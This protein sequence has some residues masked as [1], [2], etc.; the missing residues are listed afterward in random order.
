MD[1]IDNPMIQRYLWVCLKIQD[2]FRGLRRQSIIISTQRP[3][4]SELL[5]LLGLVELARV[6]W[7]N[8]SWL[9]SHRNTHDESTKMQHQCSESRQM[10]SDKCHKGAWRKTIES[11]LTN[12]WTS[13]PW[14]QYVLKNIQYCNFCVFRFNERNSYPPQPMRLVLTPSPTPL[15]NPQPPFWPPPL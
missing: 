5:R 3:L 4:L 8:C 12:S 7:N 9:W 6:P 14:K 13:W 10:T 15:H 11:R 1:A 2:N